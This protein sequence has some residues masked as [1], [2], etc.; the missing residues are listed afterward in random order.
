MIQE[1][2]TVN[3]YSILG[4]WNEQ[5]LIIKPLLDLPSN[6]ARQLLRKNGQKTYIFEPWRK[7]RKSYLEIDEPYFT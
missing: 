6:I 4:T 5:K 3:W 7:Q 1:S 2:I